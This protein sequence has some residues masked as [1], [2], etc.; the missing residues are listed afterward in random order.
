MNRP[1]NPNSLPEDEEMD[2]VGLPYTEQQD[3]T[4]PDAPSNEPDIP[5]DS[6]FERIVQPAP[7]NS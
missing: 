4:S 3:P 6:E 7:P 2:P 5:E 1:R